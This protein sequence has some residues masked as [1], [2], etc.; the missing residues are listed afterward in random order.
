[1]Q[2]RFLSRL[3]HPL[4]FFGLL[5]FLIGFGASAFALVVDLFAEHRSPYQGLLTFG[6]YPTVMA[7][8]VALALLGLFLA[9]RK[10]R[11]SEDI[12]EPTDTQVEL[13]ARRHRRILAVMSL[14]GLVL[15]MLSLVGAF[16]AY[17]YTESEE[18]CGALCHDPMAAQ[19]TAYSDSPHSRIECV[20]CHVGPG[21]RGYIEAKVSGLRQVWEVLTDTIPRPIRAHREKLPQAA[22]SC[23][24]CHSS[25]R[26]IGV[27]LLDRTRFGYDPRSSELFLRVVLHVGGGGRSSQ[28]PANG[29][30]WHADPRNRVWFKATDERELEIPWV[31]VERADGSETV[32]QRVASEASESG[33]IDGES[34]GEAAFASAES[35]ANVPPSLMDCID[36]HN[37]PTHRFYTPDRAVD[38]AIAH[39]R[40]ERSLPWIKRFA[41]LAAGREWATREAALAGIGPEMREHY[42][43]HLPTVLRDRESSV[44]AA[45]GVVG[46]LWAR[47][48]FPEFAIDSRTYPDHAGHKR[49]PGCFRC[50]D[51]KLVSADGR[52]I[53]NDCGLCHDFFQ[54]DPATGS[55]QAI[56]ADA[57]VLHPFKDPAHTEVGCW[58]CHD[59][60][61]LPT[62]HCDRCHEN[63]GEGHILADDCTVCHR[64]GAPE[65]QANTCA[66]CHPMGDSPLHAAR[67]HEDCVACH[68]PHAW[69]EIDR[70]PSACVSCHET[71]EGKPAREHRP[72]QE[73]CLGECHSFSGARAHVAG[74][75]VRGR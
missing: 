61:S 63:T 66:P 72:Q 25:E 54:R 41:V 43:D 1:M 5:L 9:R 55:L 40:V 8:G 60:R 6:L 62:S 68:H 12:T 20:E 2:S 27:V 32:Y 15:V 39:G 24:H 48:H 17:E 71:I 34:R 70:T 47:S 75:P 45:A 59:G 26:P 18:F 58:N 64:P 57:G 33:G 21:P 67:G 69:K 28:E 52:T 49:F 37:R 38:Q 42:E 35:L 4:V 7:V 10:R 14:F 50:H 44:S 36:C 56:A 22:D 74:L 29:I 53:P 73:G 19:F 31:R 13:A 51:G 23:E 11:R 46:D 30:H 16:R 3:Q 65:V